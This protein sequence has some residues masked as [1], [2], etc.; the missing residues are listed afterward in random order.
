MGYLKRMH[1]TRPDLFDA[2]VNGWLHGARAKARLRNGEHE[3]IRPAVPGKSDSYL[4]R[5]FQGSDGPG[6]GRAFL[7]DGYRLMDHLD[8]L[9]AILEG[10]EAAGIHVDIRGCDLTESRMYVRIQANEIKSYAPTLLKGYRSPFSGALGDDNPTVFAG[11]VF[12][13]SEVG[14]GALTL[15]PQLV[16]QVCDNGLTID[17]EIRREI[18]RGGQLSD[19]LIRWSDETRKKEVELIRS[20]TK[21]AVTTFLD[22]DYVPRAIA[23]L[24]ETASKPLESADKVVRAVGKKLSFSEEQ[25]DGILDHF[26]TGGQRTAGGVPGSHVLRAD[27]RQRRRR[28]RDRSPG[29]QGNGARR[30]SVTQPPRETR[31]VAAPPGGRRCAGVESAGHRARRHD[32]V[33]LWLE[34]ICTLTESRLQ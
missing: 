23:D 5:T 6:L 10:V 19:G 9:M 17:K 34:K 29:H 22:V 3:L 2:N 13:N 20:K 30:S 7:S 28:Q 12:S 33:A 21:D 18:H 8:V 15:A 27:D 25:I 1:Q 26:M 4:F 16:V 14:A 32:A 24:D 31:P 11:F